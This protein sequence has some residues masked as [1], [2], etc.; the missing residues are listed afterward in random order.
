MMGR[1]AGFLGIAL[2]TFLGLVPLAGDAAETV[3]VH[4]SVRTEGAVGEQV[5]YFR[6]FTT[7][8]QAGTERIAVS[9][10]CIRGVG[11]DKHEK[12]EEN[13]SSVE[14]VER[15]L[16]LSGV[17]SLCVDAYASAMWKGVPLAA[18]ARACP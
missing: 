18:T 3:W 6:A 12:C 5:S 16:G 13:A 15:A 1:R 9:R 8:D 17:G 10:L 14:V 11:H 7:T 2:G 4:A